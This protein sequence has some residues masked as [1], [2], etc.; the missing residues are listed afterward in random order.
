[1]TPNTYHG[2]RLPNLVFVLSDKYPII[3]VDIPS[4]I[5][6]LNITKLSKIKI[7]LTLK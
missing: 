6:P 1:M 7:Q 5:Y 2:V 3:G 4:A